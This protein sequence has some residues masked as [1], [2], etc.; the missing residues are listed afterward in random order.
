MFHNQFLS[1]RNGYICRRGH[2]E[3]RIAKG[4]DAWSEWLIT[5]IFGS[6]MFIKWSGMLFLIMFASLSQDS[7]IIL[8]SSFM[9][10]HCNIHVIQTSIHSIGCYCLFVCFC[11]IIFEFGNISFMGLFVIGQAND[12]PQWVLF[13]SICSG[14][15]LGIYGLRTF[16]ITGTICW[17]FR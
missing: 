17:N 13:R 9:T 15:V 14:R 6:E 1:K 16:W 12:Q 5:R 10:F 2:C 11:W 7:K 4:M 8:L 3:N